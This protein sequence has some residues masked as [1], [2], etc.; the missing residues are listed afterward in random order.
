[1]EK[2]I[3]TLM[4]RHGV[5]MTLVRDGTEQVFPCFFQPVRSGSYQSMEPQASPLGWLSQG[6]YTLLAPEDVP[7]QP[8]DLLRLGEKCYLVRRC[9]MVYGNGVPLYQWGL[10]VERSEEAVWGA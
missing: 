9:E 2:T 5:E 3:R 8:G 6:Q 4:T 7:V 10:C 1:M